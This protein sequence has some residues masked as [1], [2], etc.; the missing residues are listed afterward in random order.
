MSELEKYG[1]LRLYI[2]QQVTDIESLDSVGMA[3]K[4]AKQM[5]LLFLEKMLD[6]MIR[7]KLCVITHKK[8]LKP[9][10]KSAKLYFN[11]IARMFGEY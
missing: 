8:R 10:L 11:S 2:K 3:E 9:Q 6:K 5:E 7:G 4:L 1:K